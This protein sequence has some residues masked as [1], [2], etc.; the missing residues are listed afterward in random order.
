MLICGIKVTHDGGVA[1]VEDNR[2]VC[3]VEVE[4]LDNGHR[5]AELDSL[6]V[7]DRVLSDFGVAPSDVDSF[8]VDGWGYGES[9][10]VVATT[11]ANGHT[12][13]RVAPYRE[14]RLDQPSLRDYR[15]DGLPLGGRLYDYRSYHHTTGHLASAYAASPFAREGQPSFVLVWDG[16]VLPRAYYVTPDPPHIEN[17]GPIFGLIGNVYPTFAMHFPPFRPEDLGGPPER[18]AFRQLTVPG[19]VMAY[20][21][22][23]R[24]REDL[25]E[26]LDWVYENKLEAAF[27][28]A[29][30]FTLAFLDR[31]RGLTYEPADAMASFQHWVG[32]RLV[33]SLRRLRDREPGRVGNLCFSGGCALNIKW[34]SAIRA[35]G[36]FDRFWVPPFPNDSGSALGAAAAEMAR[37]RGAFDLEWSVYRG[38]RLASASGNDRYRKRACDVTELAEILHR[39]GE[40]VVVLHG[41][42]ELGPRALGNRSIIAPATGYHM[43]DRLNDIKRRE[44]YRPVSPICLEHRAPDI[45]EPGTPDP[46]MLFEHQLRPNWRSRLPAIMHLDGS[47]RLQTVNAAE[48]PVVAELLTEYERLSGV[49]VLCNTSANFE[50]HGFFPDV[51]SVMEWDRV[52]RIWSDGVLWERTEDDEPVLG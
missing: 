7:V 43:K 19:K 14:E 45:F 30:R 52:P 12:E 16:G 9:D 32:Q 10:P 29:Q 35:S 17:L 21:A 15:F 41:R 13:L 5:Y 39:T 26:A 25:C 44:H 22:L 27:D 48:N 18:A 33:A 3:S 42:A 4:K 6:S 37:V 2:L 49:P 38:P 36:V 34:N 20:T 51:D 40:P 31:T 47:A 23:G 46:Y 28:F 8:V 50:G 1:L 24:V 11:G